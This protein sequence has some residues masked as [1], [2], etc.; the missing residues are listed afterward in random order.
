M[1][2]LQILIVGV[3]SLNAA[4]SSAQPAIPKSVEERIRRADQLQDQGSLTE[5]RDLYQSIAKELP[6]DPPS[7]QLGWVL[8]GLSTVSA[9]LG[10]YRESAEAALRAEDVYRRAGDSEGQSSALNNLGIAREELG[11]Y[12]SAQASF[13]DALAVSQK[14]GD[15]ATQVRTLNNLGNAH[16]FP[17]QYLESLR[18]YQDAA[19]I[20]EGHRA[21]KWT[22]Y[23][24]QI[25]RINEATLYQRLG[26][27]QSALQ[28]YKEVEKS[29]GLSASDRGQFLTNMGVLYR[30]L[31]DSWKA[32][33]A[34]RDALA[35]NKR[36]RNSVGEIS[37]LKNI[38]IVYALDRGDLS[39]A[40]V[41]FEDALARARQTHNQREEM[42]AHLYLGET[43]LRE[44]KIAESQAEF[45]LA[46]SQA[47]ELGTVEEQWKAL[48]GMGRGVDT[49]GNSVQ[50]E[51]LYR[52]AIAIIETT[53]AQLQLSALRLEFL[54]DKRDVYDALIAILLKKN[55]VAAAFLFIERSRAR[56]FQ[57]RLT[58]SDQPSGPKPITADEVRQYLDPS[59][60]LIEFWTAGDQLVLLWCTRNTCGAKQTAITAPQRE[61]ILKFLRGLPGNLGADWRQST[62]VLAP[63]LP[64]GWPIAPGMRR[65]LIVPDGW[66]SS[67]PF[68]LVPAANSQAL[69]EQLEIS[70]LPT[71]VLL[72]RPTLTQRWPYLPWWREMV[73]FG[74]PEVQGSRD[75]IALDH[76][77]TIQPLPYSSEEILAI[78]QM[79]YGRGDLFLGAA[80]L[81]DTFLAAEARG[82]PILHVST[83]AFADADVPEDSRILFS[84]RAGDAPDYLFLRELHEL[85]LREVNL[86][87]LS[88]CD[89]ERGQMIRGEGVQ[90]F[91]RA[92][93]FAG[94]RSAVTTLW[95]VSDQ[96]TSEFMKQFYYY[97]LQK[98]QPKAE[99]LRSA[100]LKFLQ[101]QTELNNPAHW[102]AFVITGDGITRL[103][104][105]FSWTELALGVLAVLLGLTGGTMALL[106]IRRR[107]DGV[108]R[109]QNVVS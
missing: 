96:P 21:E 50:A 101:S 40:Q 20:I 94:A 82:A 79:L 49:S 7:R 16:Y 13:R 92:L 53:R 106:R 47:R 38:G 76:D 100:K 81:K 36:Q 85:D 14:S 80:D 84:P 57:D 2:R 77:G 71:A 18:A 69:I 42:Q 33:D 26:R 75:S 23:W 65:A 109:A 27:Y 78:A 1:L 83:H 35:L 86:A 15:F 91:S 90:A 46:L 63:I 17:G 8:N 108:D 4:L 51:D 105:F 104:R 99:A 25:T 88:A 10:D 3:V 28:I 95:R 55:D 39:R 48:Y 70:Y 19:R 11:D 93:L 9:A 32:L 72:R 64:G 103:P 54:A 87:T 22:D 107:I 59:T 37:T 60:I 68:D 24:D 29:K 44:K 45:Q 102:A 58:S 52:Q 73:A 97:A 74:N 61:E 30:R 41:F 31:G 67:V 89:T 6:V 98:H 56:T 5:A 66:V 34:Y 12:P 62:A 43:K